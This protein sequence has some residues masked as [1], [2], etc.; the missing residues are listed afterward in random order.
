MALILASAF[1]AVAALAFPNPTNPL[2]RRN[3][4]QAQGTGQGLD[5][6][7][8]TFT[9][10][11][12]GD[13]LRQPKGVYKGSYGFYEAH[14][15]MSYKLSRPLNPNEVLDFYSGSATDLSVNHTYNPAV[16]N[17]Y[18]EACWLYDATA[19]VNATTQDDLGRE[20]GRKAGCHTLLQNEWCA[21]I[22]TH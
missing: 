12:G 9:V 5:F 6:D 19:G 8:L 13:C 22:W 4:P 1:L 20:E 11:E 10:Y 21:I 16:E 3:F 14:Q 7:K 2:L 15:M 18:T 17:H